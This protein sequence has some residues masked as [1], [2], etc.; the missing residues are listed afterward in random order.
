MKN[1]EI[2]V[3]E[4]LDLLLGS[5]SLEEAQMLARL[6][7]AIKLYEVGR[8]SSGHAADIAGLSRRNFL[9]ELPRYGV[10]SVDWDEEEIEVEG[11]S[12]E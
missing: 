10:P 9:L 8:I 7:L 12:L 6:L 1:L 11:K 3:P 5:A 2:P 4:N